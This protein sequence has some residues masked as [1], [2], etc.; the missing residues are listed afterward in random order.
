MGLCVTYSIE[1]SSK[2]TI[3]WITQTNLICKLY[4][5]HVGSH[6]CLNDIIV[7]FLCLALSST[8]VAYCGANTACKVLFFRNET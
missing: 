4:M 8:I 6:D 2:W 5:V 1:Q 3:G 7:A